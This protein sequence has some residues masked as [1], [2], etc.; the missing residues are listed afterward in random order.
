[1]SVDVKVRGSDAPSIGR[2]MLRKVPEI[3][4]W[5]WIIKVLCTTVGE[6]FADWVNTSLGVVYGRLPGEARRR[7]LSLSR[8]FWT[9]R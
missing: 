2:K 6:S 8:P 5:F 7:R 3:T 9:Y 1:M 4:I